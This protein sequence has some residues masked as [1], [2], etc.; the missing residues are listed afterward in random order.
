MAGKTP[1]G[2]GDRAAD[3][4]S[5]GCFGFFASLLPFLPLDMNVSMVEYNTI[6]ASRIGI[7]NLIVPAPGAAGSPPPIHPRPDARA[8]LVR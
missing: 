8:R 4:G 7:V 3:C 6:R 1:V 5:F 2:V